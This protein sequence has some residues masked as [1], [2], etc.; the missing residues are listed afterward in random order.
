MLD[1]LH[2]REQVDRGWMLLDQH[3]SHLAVELG[4]LLRGQVLG[5]EDEDRYVAGSRRGSQR[6]HDVEAAHLGHHEVEDHHVRTVLLGEGDA[7]G[8]A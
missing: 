3:S 2:P 8:A 6:R 4:L 7:L 1:P 5:S